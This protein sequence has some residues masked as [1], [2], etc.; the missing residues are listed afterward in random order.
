MLATTTA[1]ARCKL[2]NSGNL[3]TSNGRLEEVTF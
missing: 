2:E 1:T 3:T